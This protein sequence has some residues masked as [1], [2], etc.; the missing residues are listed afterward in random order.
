MGPRINGYPIEG[1]GATDERHSLDAASLAAPGLTALPW[2]AWVNASKSW[3]G[4]VK[5]DTDR[6]V[7]TRW[8]RR[9]THVGRVAVAGERI[10]H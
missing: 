5:W 8:R 6:S 4:R 3:D 7:F 9:S 2:L 1:E 10:L